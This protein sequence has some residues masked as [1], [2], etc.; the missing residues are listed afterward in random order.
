MRRPP[1]FMGVRP[2]SEMGP[3]SHTTIIVPT[4]I[5]ENPFTYLVA[6]HPRTRGAP[7]WGKPA[8]KLE[9]AMTQSTHMNDFLHSIQNSRLV[10][11]LSG[12]DRCIP[13][14]NNLWA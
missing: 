4:S 2:S 1:A 14:T 12:S 9:F 3:T 13:G 7:R 10:R 11:M 6:S 5:S 8:C